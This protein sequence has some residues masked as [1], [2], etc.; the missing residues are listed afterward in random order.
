MSLE[1]LIFLYLDNIDHAE[2]NIFS[3]CFK[4]EVDMKVFQPFI[5]Y[6][7]SRIEFVIQSGKAVVI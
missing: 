7:M 5:P 1:I 6:L 2:W 3:H 4:I